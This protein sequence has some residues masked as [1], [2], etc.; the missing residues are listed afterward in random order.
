MGNTILDFCEDNITRLNLYSGNMSLTESVYEQLDFD[1]SRVSDDK[2][3]FKSIEHN[4]FPLE[5]KCRNSM[6]S[7]KAAE[8][9][10]YCS[11]SHSPFGLLDDEPD[12]APIDEWTPPEGFYLWRI[13]RVF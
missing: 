10:V 2:F 1:F 12:N 7:K 4:L 8:G 6:C 11:K 9:K 3:Q 13:K 5:N